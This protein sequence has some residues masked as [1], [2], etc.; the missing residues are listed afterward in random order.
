MPVPITGFKITDIQA[1]LGESGETDAEAL[2]LSENV[3]PTGLDPNYCV[4]LA[5]LRTK[6]YDI[7]KWRNYKQS[8]TI[9]CGVESS[10]GGGQ[11]YPSSEDIL[12]GSAL[13]TVILYPTP[14]SVPDRFIVFYNQVRVIDT[15]YISSDPSFHN[16]GGPGRI[17][18]KNNLT[19]K[20]DPVLGITYPN[21]TYFPED[22]YPLVYSI[23]PKFFY[24]SLPGVTEA[25][26][27]V[28]APSMGTS[29]SY[30]LTCP[31]I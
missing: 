26:V 11:S 15:G 6:P 10:Y 2:F 14:L 7:G 22:G 29:W 3:N 9:A 16:P 4:S 24:K 1:E 30:V 13:G 17:T 21:L 20:I 19:G 5:S 25:Q 31:E 12:L 27:R 28:Y 8:N 18:F 23:E